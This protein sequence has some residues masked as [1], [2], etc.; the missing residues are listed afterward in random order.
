MAYNRTTWND[1]PNTTT[2]ITATRLNNMETGI[3]A[4]DN[5][6]STDVYSSSRTY[7]IGELCLYNNRLYRCITAISTAEAFN[8]AKWT[9]T[10][11]SKEVKKQIATFENNATTTYHGNSYI[12]FG[13]TII[14]TVSDKIIKG[15]DGL[16]TINHNGFIKVSFNV[17]LGG[18]AGYRPLLA[19][20]QDNPIAN[21]MSTVG[22]I[23]SSGYLSLGASNKVIPAQSG[24]KIGV[25]LDL[26]QGQ[27]DSDKTVIID[28]DFL[29]LS[30]ITIELL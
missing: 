3:S 20:H 13:N 7:N 25:F 22:T 19:L 1:L 16:F 12:V 30:Y 10:T 24:K 9:Q 27:G 6:I 29:N 28:K 2:P 23:G 4:N 18:Q 15:N 5:N 8:S 21:Y 11:L 14:N 26:G 17:W